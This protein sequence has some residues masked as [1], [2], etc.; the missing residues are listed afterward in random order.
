MYFNE[1]DKQY[2]DRIEWAELYYK[3]HSI[4]F[5]DRNHM[6]F[7]IGSDVVKTMYKYYYQDW[8]KIPE[9]LHIQTVLSDSLEKIEKAPDVESTAVINTIKYTNSRLTEKMNHGSIYG[10]PASW[11][12]WWR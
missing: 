6:V 10:L 11:F 1:E 4:R 12:V 2:E 9:L 3:N 7:Q 5:W 8:E